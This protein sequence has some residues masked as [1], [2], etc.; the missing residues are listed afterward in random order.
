MIFFALLPHD[1]GTPVIP[2]GWLIR[3]EG[4]TGFFSV[5]V[6]E[7]SPE[8]QFL[9]LVLGRD[10]EHLLAQVHVEDGLLSRVR[11][12][13][14]VWYASLRDGEL[15]GPD[16]EEWRQGRVRAEALWPD[17]RPRDEHGEFIDPTEPRIA[18]A[19]TVA[20]VDAKER[21]QNTPRPGRPETLPP[22]RDREL[23]EPAGGGR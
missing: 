2:Q 13:L 21:T 6:G 20:G 7:R 16:E 4:N 5:Y 9:V 12:L 11:P 14:G 23:P 8:N 17:R 22:G 15:E 3:R 18:V 1:H 19:A 10:D